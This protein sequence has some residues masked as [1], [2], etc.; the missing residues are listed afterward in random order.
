MCVH[1]A[2]FPHFSF[3]PVPQQQLRLLMVVYCQAFLATNL[4]IIVKMSGE[5]LC[6]MLRIPLQVIMSSSFNNVKETKD[7]SGEL[8]ELSKKGFSRGGFLHDIK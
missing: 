2:A 4:L 8:V 7:L 1:A 6:E 3:F 5:E